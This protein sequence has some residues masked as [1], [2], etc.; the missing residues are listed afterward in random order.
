MTNPAVNI[1]RWAAIALGASIPISTALDNVLL[2]VVLA[3]WMASG[4]VRDT[5]KNLF[6]N[7]ALAISLL[8]FAC[9]AMGTLWSRVPLREALSH[10]W[11]YAD[12]L[13]IP[14]FAM[15]FRDPETRRKGLYAFAAAM[16][17]TLVLSYLLYVKLIPKWAFFAYDGVSPTVFKFKI[18]HSILL[19]FAACL[20]VWL[21]DS[22]S[23]LRTRFIW[24]ALALLAAC[25]VLLLVQG[26][27]GY[28]V[29]GILALFL[30]VQRARPRGLAALAALAALAVVA[31]AALIYLP[32]PFQQR[33]TLI[34]SELNLWR[35]GDAKAQDTST[36]QRLDFHKNTL[37]I[38]AAH[39]FTGVGT[40]GFPKAYAEQVK[41]TG[42]YETHNPHNE[43]L[44]IAAQIGLGGMLLLIV[45]FWVQWRAAPQLATPM[46]QSLAR[47]LVLTFVA[48][49]LVNSMLLDHAEG[50]FYA[51]M[52]GL[53]YG[54]LKYGPP[55][56]PL[57]TTTPS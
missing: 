3:A 45:M 24:Y 10:L 4:Q 2:V 25:N 44:N 31:G 21:G 27:T 32:T 48:G 7:K 30:V 17:V 1:S 20:F 11:K 19:A 39:P 46:E 40:G 37:G 22:T 16:V 55:D 43:F 52:S 29:L 51:W 50:L 23:R 49:C 26:A 56:N 41:G 12:L 9:L 47:A 8:L 36:G 14:L 54:G 13:F 35:S 28:L 15:A 5:A 18:T 38:I 6:K 34:Q 33:I 53:L 57:K 42:K